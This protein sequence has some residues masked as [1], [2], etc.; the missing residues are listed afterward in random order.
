MPRVAIAA[1]FWLLACT[2]SAPQPVDPD[3]APELP[4]WRAHMERVDGMCSELHRLLVER[5]QGD[6]KRASATARQA[7]AVL[8]LGY[9]P[10]E[11]RDVPGY[12]GF[13]R[14]AEN[15]LLQVAIA[16]RQGHGDLA[17]DAFQE[18]R[19]RHCASCHD[20]AERSSG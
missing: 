14:A 5:P 19:R 16:A 4:S 11:R 2:S 9:G 1:S 13:A 8:Q 15:W 12:A 17:A 20:A 10:F 6:L 3:A 18:G 7:A